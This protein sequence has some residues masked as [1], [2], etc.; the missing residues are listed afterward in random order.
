[1]DFLFR[2]VMARNLRSQWDAW[3]RSRDVR[4]VGILKTVALIEVVVEYKDNSEV[5][6]VTASIVGRQD[7]EKIP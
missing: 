4:T 5:L 1:M 3:R 2:R 7:T 6:A